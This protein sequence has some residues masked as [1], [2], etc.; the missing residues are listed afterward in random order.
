MAVLRVN[1]NNG[2][3]TLPPP[4]D[5][6]LVSMTDTSLSDILLSGYP[7]R[8]K[9]SVGPASDSDDFLEFWDRIDELYGEEFG[10]QF[11]SPGKIM[12]RPGEVSGDPEGWAFTHDATTL[13]GN[14][15]SP[16]ISL[17][18]AMNFCGLHFG[19]ATLPQNLAHD[20]QTVL[21]GGDGIFDTDVL[22]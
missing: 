12:D 11:L 19:G 6:D 10:K 8:P 5:R 15:G 14:S 7:A 4:L 13:G 2:Q 20:I 17:H 18:G 1:P 16:I 21:S 9:G 3:G 22:D